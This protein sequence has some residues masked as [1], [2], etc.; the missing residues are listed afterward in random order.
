MKK[1]LSLDG[2]RDADVETLAAIPSMNEQAAKSVYE[3][4][5]SPAVEGD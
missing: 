3:F 5:H 1:F 2:I 4:F